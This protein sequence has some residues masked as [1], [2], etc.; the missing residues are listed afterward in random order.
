MR[1]ITLTEEEANILKE[2]LDTLMMADS[3]GYPATELGRLFA[4]D[5][6]GAPA[7]WIEPPRLPMTRK[8]FRLRTVG[9]KLHEAPKTRAAYR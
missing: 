6:G 4:L 5:Q 2:V 9:H 7:S 1:T 3:D 8:V